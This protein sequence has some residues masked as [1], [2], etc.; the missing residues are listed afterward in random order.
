MRE[1]EKR[2]IKIIGTNHFMPENLA[3]YIPGVTKIKPIYNRVL[4]NW[5]LDGYNRMELVTAQS[6]AAANLIRA[7][8]LKPPVLPVS[9]GIDLGRFR[10]D[11]SIDRLACRERYGLDPKRTLFLYVGR[12]EKDKRID[13]LLHALARLKRDDIQLVIAGRGSASEYFQALARTLHLSGRVRF[14]G[15]IPRED[16]H[17]LLNSV[18]IFSMPS[19]A[20]LLSLASLEAMA[21]GRPMLLANA[22][23]LPELVAPGVNGYLFKPND[24]DD[25]AHYMQILADQPERW[26]DMGRASLEKAKV[27]SL[28][29]TVQRY[30]EIYKKTLEE[31]PVIPSPVAGPV[32]LE[33]DGGEHSLSSQESALLR[34]GKR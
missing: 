15:F 29:N 23:A 24:A 13:V 6:R 20:E 14:T 8:G 2:G 27:H 1:A 12:I 30:E 22:V 26:E 28:E 32:G 25:A 21:C 3:Q 4:W 7:K 10:W 17:V 31:I 16:L 33:I 9:C 34:R 11:A 18:D 19:D 5:M